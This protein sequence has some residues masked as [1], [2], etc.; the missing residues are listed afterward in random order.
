M[1]LVLAALAMLVLAASAAGCAPRIGDGCASQTNCSINGDRVCDTTQPGGYCTVF[2][3]SPDTCPDDAV[4]VRFEPDTPRLSR[5]VCMRRCG[6]NGD[7]RTNYTCVANAD[8]VHTV[9][10]VET[11]LFVVNDLQRPDGRFCLA[12]Q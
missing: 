3:C 9:D 4:C 1:R 2:D 5:T 10:G 7:C 8:G 12:P 11:H 6:S